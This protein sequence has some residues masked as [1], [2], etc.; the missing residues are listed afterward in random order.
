[1]R[2]TENSAILR[3]KNTDSAKYQQLM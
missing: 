3:L 2:T 1:V